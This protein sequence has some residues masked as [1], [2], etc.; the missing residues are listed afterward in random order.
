MRRNDDIGRN[1]HGGN[2]ASDDAFRNGN[3]P[4]R[5]SMK[6]KLFRACVESGEYGITTDEMEIRFRFSHQSASAR[7]SELKDEGRIMFK[8]VR[9][10]TRWGGEAEVHVVA[11]RPGYGSPVESGVPSGMLFDMR[12]A[13]P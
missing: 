10:E 7:M 11:K 12:G 1:R 3:T 2:P 6:E 4:R 8:G 13:R 5:E 9:R